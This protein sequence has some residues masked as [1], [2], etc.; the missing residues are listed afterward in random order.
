MRFCRNSV[1]VSLWHNRNVGWP[2]PIVASS[3][4]R[5]LYESHMARNGTPPDKAEYMAAF[6]GI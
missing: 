5:Q 4:T 1:G 6:I 2:S 3:S